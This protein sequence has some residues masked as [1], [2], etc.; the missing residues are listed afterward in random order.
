[1]NISISAS[2]DSVN[3]DLQ[4]AKKLAAKLDQIISK[5]ARQW[6]AIRKTKEF[7]GGRKGSSQES[8]KKGQDATL[9]AFDLRLND[10]LKS[11]YQMND[12]VSNAA[13]FFERSVL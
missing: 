1:M 9:K 5:V 4:E 7:P 10:A 11:V 12:D 13:E 8:A 6:P 2:P 3:K